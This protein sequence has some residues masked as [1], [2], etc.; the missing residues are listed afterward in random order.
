[1]QVGQRNLRGRPKMTKL[2][3]SDYGFGLIGKAASEHHIDK[4]IFTK[5]M[6][7]ALVG[8]ILAILIAAS[9]VTP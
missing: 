3:L 4:P 8:A 9:A 6:I 2:P 7:V 1:M 5:I